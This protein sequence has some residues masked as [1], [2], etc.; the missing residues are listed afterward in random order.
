MENE[1]DRETTLYSGW[2]RAS[3]ERASEK[4]KNTHVSMRATTD[5][6]RKAKA[7]GEEKAISNSDRK[8]VY[9]QV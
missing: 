1:R 5:S 4:T 9:T 8:T 6:T 7:K 2:H 3:A